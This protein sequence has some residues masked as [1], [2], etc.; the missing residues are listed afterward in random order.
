MHVTTFKKWAAS[1]PDDGLI[2]ITKRGGYSRDWE[3][4][5][6]TEIRLVCQ[7]PIQEKKANA[8]ENCT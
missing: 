4:L 7:P 6:P 3:P 8:I 2:E 1:L 5:D